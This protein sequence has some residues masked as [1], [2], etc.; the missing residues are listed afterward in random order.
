M[1]SLQKLT[2]NPL[3]DQEYFEALI[4]KGIDERVVNPPKKIVIWFSAKWCGPCKR[5]DG[6][7]LLKAF[8]EI[9]FFKCD[10]D[11]NNYTPGYCG[12]RAIPA[13]MAMDSGKPLSSLQDSSTQ[14][15]AAWIQ[16]SFQISK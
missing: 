3:P 12:V 9:T 16:T 7:A 1:M 4:G 15:I 14:V 8:P 2:M 10:M 5:V 11:E 13:F 6:E